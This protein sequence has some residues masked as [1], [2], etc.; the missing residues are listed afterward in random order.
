MEKKFNNLFPITQWGVILTTNAVFVYKYIT[1]IDI[2]PIIVTI[3][4]FFLFSSAI[5]LYCHN[6]EKYIT[7]SI[8]RWFSIALTI[9]IIGIIACTIFMIDPLSIRVDRWSATS[10]FLDALT[11]GVYPYGVHTHVFENNYPS[12]FPLWHYLNIP[13]W[14]I[15]DVGWIQVFMLLFFL[16]SIYLYFQSWRA[17]LYAIII[18][19][20]SPAY[21]WEIVT[22]SDGLSN[23]LLVCSC[24]LLIERYGIT[25][26]KQWWLLAIIAGCIASTRLSAI[27]PIAL[28]LF[29]P[30]IDAT[31]KQKIGFISIAAGI[32]IFAFAP[33]I[34]WDT[35][36]WIFFK[37]NPFMSQTSPGNP[38]ILLV[39]VV[40]AILIAYK[41]QT[42]YYFFSTTSVFMFTFMLI[43]QLGVVWR[44]GGEVTLYDPGFDIS[45]FTLATPYAIIALYSQTNE[46]R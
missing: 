25:M 12:P 46:H 23:A 2:N 9:G 44:S 26:S 35:T 5:Y 39:M 24:I 31:W 28:Y 45:Y 33:Y 8:A 4:F 36:E 7:E 17:V 13:F 16:G 15:G 1:R 3:V 21:W 29:R 43:T 42:P 14:L 19:C 40:I 20:I 22:R 18:L 27:I 6:I 11:T 30:W 41:K 37:R 32:V 10:Y 38:W 34:L